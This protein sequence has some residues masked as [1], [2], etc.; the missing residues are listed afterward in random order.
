MILHQESLLYLRSVRK[1]KALTLTLR[2]TW[3]LLTW[4]SLWASQLWRRPASGG[5]PVCF[6]EALKLEAGRDWTP[7]GVQHS[8][9]ERGN[10]TLHYHVRVWMS[11]NT[12]GLLWHKIKQSNALPVKQHDTLFLPPGGSGYVG[13]RGLM[14]SAGLE[15]MVS[16]LM[17]TTM[18]SFSPKVGIIN[19]KELSLLQ[20]WYLWCLDVLKSSL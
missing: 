1:V 13:T 19:V 7:R 6:E 2:T 4:R 14:S 10:I 8:S 12:I 5:W 9:R 15:V 18:V 3:F 16:G 20:F 11:E 17:V